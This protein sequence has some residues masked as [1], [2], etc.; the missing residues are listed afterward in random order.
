[1]NN[2]HSE[3][4]RIMQKFKPF[5]K[6]NSASSIQQIDVFSTTN[7]INLNKYDLI[8]PFN[9]KRKLPEKLSVYLTFVDMSHKQKLI[10]LSLSLKNSVSLLLYG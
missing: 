7:L 6:K 10:L 3:E 1:M 2:R 9:F 4:L 5:L 8:R